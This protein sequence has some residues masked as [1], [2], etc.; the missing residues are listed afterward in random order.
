MSSAGALSP[1]APALAAWHPALPWVL[2]L[3]AGL[4]GAWAM[5]PL[6]VLLGTAPFWDNPRGIVGGSWADMLTASSGYVAFVRDGWRW[7]LFQVAGL[8][9]EGANVL[10]TDSVPAVAL[11]G[12]LLFRLT[13]QVVPLYGV[14]T[15]VC[16]AGMGLA[17]TA[18]VRALG[19]RSPAAALAASAIG[20]SMP[21]LVGRW[22]HLALMGQA[23][24]PLA[25]VIYLRL[26]A[27]PRL[28]AGT[29]LVWSLGL[30]LG[31]LLV[32][33]YLLLM[34]GGIM[35]AAL[36]QAATDRRLSWPAAAG[37]L[38]ALAGA[39]GTAMWAMGYGASSG[40]PSD[41][42]F[43]VYSANLLSLL[44]PYGGTLP[45]GGAFALD[46]TGGQYEGAAFLGFGVL[47]LVLLGWRGMAASLASAGPRHPWLLL[48][49]TGFSVLAVSNEVYLGGLH[50]LSVP[51]PDQA[52]WL[53]GAV[54]S[55]GRFAWVAAYLLAAAAVAAVARRRDGARLLLLAA[56]L[57]FGGV[58]LLCQG[59]RAAA[60]AMP[61]PVLDRAAWMAALPGAGQLVVDPPFACLPQ[62]E[63]SV[64]LRKA[65][66]ELQWMAAQSAVP[67]NTLYAARTRPDCVVPPLAERAIVAYLRPVQPPPGLACQA[68]PLM[69]VCG[70][71]PLP[72]S[73]AVVTAE[74]V[75]AAP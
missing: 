5:L 22:G 11:L 74:D 16:I 17:C 1:P 64:P 56:A 62:D 36:L 35:V 63:S 55:S 15:L 73:L 34:A 43:G 30:C 47:L 10:F 27:A 71:Q 44:A 59:I 32:H 39:V 53:L 14:W 70:P 7:P 48:A 4:A 67:T 26:R 13:G 33:P 72:A 58:A 18:L 31:A 38:A 9:R 42:G 28:R 50:L 8:G 75:P 57:Q 51:L 69:T 3:L 37:V 68:G 6:P 40:A 20:V 52:L 19:A 21:A 66:V 23:L 12:R 29:A 46:G 24:I 45:G 61:Q 60:G 25:F 65:A 41:V 49:V 2:S 54:R